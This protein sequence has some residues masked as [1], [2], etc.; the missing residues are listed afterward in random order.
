MALEAGAWLTGLAVMAVAN[1][2]SPAPV[3]LCLFNALG[4]AFCPGD[5]LGHAIGFLARGQWHLALQSH[6][7][8]PLVV[9]G[10]LA[11]SGSLF[12]NLFRTTCRK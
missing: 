6:W 12:Y 4:L 7:A 8:S 9:I 3:D 5:G 11:R 10:L 1:P 2:W